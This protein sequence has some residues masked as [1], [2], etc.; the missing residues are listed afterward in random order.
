MDTA[1]LDYLTPLLNGIDQWS[2]FATLLP[3]LVLLELILSADNAVALAS[4][5]KRLDSIEL[6]QKSLNIG[7]AIS[8][9]FRILLILAANI[10]IK[11]PIIQIAASVYLISIVLTKFT[12]NNPTNDESS[13]ISNNNKSSFIKIT[14]LLIA[15]D[16]AFSIDSVTAAVAIS[17]QILLVI[18]GALIGVIALRFTAD[19]FIRWLDIFV[20]L[21]NAGY[22]AVALVAIKLLFEVTFPNI[23]IPEY[24]FYI[25]LGFVFL[26]GFSKRVPLNSNE[27]E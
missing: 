27:N 13:S 24:I 8:L 26:W 19:L 1:S 12:I 18:I 25:L 16:L 7:I 6:Q 17:D 2:E 20:Q 4:I 10:I 15:T 9:I 11:Y 21:E 3:F 23:V 22:F 5:T 14:F